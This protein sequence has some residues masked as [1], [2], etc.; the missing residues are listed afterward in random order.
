MQL[1]KLEMVGFKSFANKTD[2][3]FEP[4]VTCIV[5]PNGCGKSNVVDA[6][7]WVLGT[8]SYKS[9]RGEEMMDVIFKGAD[10]IAAAGYT[11]VSLTLDNGD[12]ALPIE[13]DEVTITRRLHRDGV[14]EYLVNKNP[15]R[16]KDI[17]DLLYGTGIG[18]DNYSIIEQGKI[19]KL[20]TSDPKAR[21]LVFDEAAGIS[22]YRARRK[23][24]ELRLE[25]V[26]GDLLRMGDLTREV[27]RQLRSVRGQAA[28]A[29]AYKRLQDEYREKKSKVVRHEFTGLQA[30][31][32]ATLA[33]I[34][35][36]E[37]KKASL[38][39]DLAA[40]RDEAAK[41]DAELAGLDEKRAGLENELS[42][43]SSKA[44]F[45]QKTIADYENRK[46]ELD[47]DRANAEGQRDE[48]LRQLTSR[49][50]LKLEEERGRGELETEYAAVSARI[51]DAKTR[52]DDA[53]RECRR[54]E[55]EI[56]SRKNER[57][58]L[59]H[60]E[61]E[62]KAQRSQIESE[63]Q[64]LVARAAR[65]ASQ[66]ALVEKELE[67]LNARRVAEDMKRAGLE[68]E[69]A[70]L[71]RRLD[72]EEAEM[73]RLRDE[74]VKLD[75]ELG[76]LRSAKEARASRQSTLRELEMAY[77]GLGEGT[78][79]LLRA[80]LPGVR[81]TLADLI[82]ANPEDVAVVENALGD[83][84]GM[85]VVDTTEQA[86]AAASFARSHGRATIV[87]LDSC[88]PRMMTVRYTPGVNSRGHE[89]VRCDDVVQPLVRALLGDV[90]VVDGVEDAEAL[91]DLWPG[92]SRIVTRSGDVFDPNGSVTAGPKA[93]GPGLL[94]RRVELKKL[95]V[96]IEEFLKLIS[97]R[98]S[99]KSECQDFLKAAEGRVKGLRQLGYDRHV[100][101]T[102]VV[103]AL[104]AVQ[105][106]H[107]LAGQELMTARAE[108][109]QIE[110]LQAATAESAA[111]MEALL[112]DLDA[113]R[114]QLGR[115]AAVLTETQQKYSIA[116]TELQNELNA[117]MV[118]RGQI[119]EKL[120]GAD[121][122]ISRLEADIAQQE[123]VVRR[124]EESLANADARLASV[125]QE[126]ER[127]RR[128]GEALA[129]EL[130]ERRAAVEAL[131]TECDAAQ[132]RV[133]EANDKAGA[134]DQAIRGVEGE[135]NQFAI[136][137]AQQE[138]TIQQCVE[139]AR[140]E[141]SI[142]LLGDAPPQEEGLDWETLCQEAEDLRSR[143]NNFGN[144]NTV[145]LDELKELEERDA[146]MTTQA[147]DLERT[148]GQLE[149]LIRRINKESKELFDRTLE[150]VREQFGTIF[151][152]VFGGG[153]ADI[154]V[155]E[156]PGV[157]EM[158]RGLEVMAR[159]P[160]REMLPISMLSGGQKSLTAF[161]LVMALFK[162]NPSP[163]CI[164]DE[165]DAPL[166]EANVGKYTNIVMEHV[167]ETQFIIISHR[168][169]TMAIAD[170]LYGVTMEQQGVSKRVSVDM[171]GQNLDVLRDRR[172]KLKALRAES[173]ARKAAAM[174]EVK[175]AAGRAI[176]VED[177]AA[178]A[179][180]G[181]TGT[182]TAVMEAPAAA[183]PK[184]KRRKS[185]EPALPGVAETT[186]EAAA[187]AAPLDPPK[188]EGEPPVQS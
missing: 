50:E 138:M 157:E 86:K 133:T 109:K 174:A 149:D 123:D 142:D 53:N 119:E 17:R 49:R 178:A 62:Y 171:H 25:K 155:Q 137:K 35:E 43:A 176:D 113:L 44:E 48:A 134:I 143:I 162:A 168:H 21:R 5:G 170:V 100:A 40:R 166:D 185:Q 45:L 159:M 141:L 173:T 8:Q 131:R 11:E 72:L 18:A 47:S 122:S 10:G 65:V 120:R 74:L 19:D 156:E 110:A 127:N 146:L 60:K 88:R 164:L 187:E 7:K 55:Q 87:S 12:H 97:A 89:L 117:Q 139:K 20:I 99:R 179:I 23:E 151:R 36:I 126:I 22:K 153:K 78:R 152:K 38:E 188:P 175:A 112:R 76:A 183:E 90:L 102:E 37:T 92:S 69:M 144:V 3:L 103:V 71:K 98:E 58:E 6:I 148:K 115:E 108:A 161:S 42:A 182:Q 84:A 28:R 51:E 80:G 2:I 66:A 150:F 181:A 14:G 61:A 68:A 91:S 46:A 94:S 26:S 33:R 27:Q 140:E 13:F 85:I 177:A 124:S 39:S 172:D 52:L 95:E 160:G 83:A 129:K 4:G 165:A 158:D 56:E 184:R 24:T 31:F 121:Q 29:S 32:A 54:L 145:A 130:E 154:I 167:N 70:D 64:A 105:K 15:C 147:E 118:G 135:Q 57:A 125:M 107:A 186:G 75:E 59:A 111:R 9:V 67:E 169:P 1:K 16:L 30:E 180:A 128:D 96:E 79:A 114:E 104:Q 163:F 101:Y 77:E 82:E 63:R 116:R 106:R 73:S 132:A 136:Q 93:G 34:A 81:G 41:A